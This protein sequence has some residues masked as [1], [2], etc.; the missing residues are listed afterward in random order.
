MKIT[1][2]NKK[3]SIKDIF[4]IERKLSITLEDSFRDFLLE[5][6]GGIP[7]DNEFDIPDA[8]NDASVDEFFSLDD[9]LR[10]HNTFRERIP[11][12]YIPIAFASGGNYICLS[13]KNNSI[14]FW[15]HEFEHEG[16]KSIFFLSKNFKTFL[17]QIKDFDP[18]SV[19]LDPEKVK[20]VW[21]DPAF[22]NELKNKGEL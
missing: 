20:H 11:N 14:F 16:E 13:K 1:K 5:S 6:N 2:K 3:I 17:K 7:S 8:N 9:I 10:N 19:E 22:L 12:N 21:V 15:D 18:N 4:E